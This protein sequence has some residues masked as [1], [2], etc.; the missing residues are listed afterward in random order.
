MLNSNVSRESGLSPDVLVQ[1]DRIDLISDQQ[2]SMTLI[3]TN[4]TAGQIDGHPVRSVSWSG[5][6]PGGGTANGTTVNEGILAGTIISCSRSIPLQ[7]DQNASA[8]FTESQS[9]VRVLRPSVITEAENT[10]P[11]IVEV[12]YREGDWYAEGLSLIHI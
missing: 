11:E 8:Y 5:Y 6:Y 1:G 2:L 3:V 7:Q 4:E 9:I 10:I 12:S